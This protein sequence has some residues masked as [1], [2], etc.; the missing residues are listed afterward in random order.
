M[1]L[2]V[3][4]RAWT[5]L[6]AVVA[7]ACFT[8]AGTAAAGTLKPSKTGELDCN[9]QSTKQTSVSMRLNCTDI[10]G[11]DNE[12]NANTWGGR[13]YDNGFYIGHDEPDMTFLSN[14]PGSGDNVTWT[15]TIRQT[16]APRQR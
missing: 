5:A 13:F 12:W 14:K 2:R 6:L 4:L 9:G 15:E 7:L 3:G 16:R 11:F 8:S 10:R 1:S